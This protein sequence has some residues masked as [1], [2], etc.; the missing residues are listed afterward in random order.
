MK[1][2]IFKLL[3]RVVGFYRKEKNIFLFSQ[4]SG[5]IK[6]LIIGPDVNS[7][8]IL[9]SPKKI[10]IGKHV[11]IN[12]NCYINAEGGVEIGSYCHIGKG[13]TI[14]SSNHNYRSD[15]LIPYDE[16]VLLKPVIIK[17]CVWIGA[18]VTI[19]PGI[20][21]G[22]GVVIGSG[23]VVTKDIPDYA[24]VGGNPAKIIKYRDI[25]MYE[26]LKKERRFY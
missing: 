22:E 10:T 23:A 14:F 9:N 21:V 25:E 8:F 5:E 4:V 20:T 15:R 3:N 17:D 24:I 12:G 1:R 11:V 6:S 2:L 18:N 13:L 16:I 7:N 26:K 19:V